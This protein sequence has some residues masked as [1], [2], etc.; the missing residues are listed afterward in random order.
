MSDSSQRD[1]AR[2]KAR[3]IASSAG[4]KRQAAVGYTGTRR[5]PIRTLIVDNSPQIVQSLSLFFKTEEGFELAGS[6]SNRQEAVRRV[7]T[8]RPDLV[9]MDVLMPGMDGLEAT[10]RIKGREGA[11][12][13][14]IF[15]LEDGDGCRLAAKTA[16]ADAF[17][18]KVPKAARRLRAAIRRAFPGANVR[19]PR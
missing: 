16:G 10:R 14:I 11:P 18:G 17:V 12:V 13:V 9:V 5:R 3:V 4:G 7:V 2:I 8:L 6:A 19:W 1:P 15:A